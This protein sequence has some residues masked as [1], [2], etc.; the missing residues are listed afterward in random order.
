MFRLLFLLTLYIVAV[1]NFPVGF[2][3][4]YDLK[5]L[6]ARREG[7]SWN[8]LLLQKTLTPSGTSECARERKLPFHFTRTYTRTHTPLY[9]SSVAI[10]KAFASLFHVKTRNFFLVPKWEFLREAEQPGGNYYCCESACNVSILRLPLRFYQMWH[11]FI[12]T[13]LKKFSKKN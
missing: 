9:C 7:K 3:P 11:G 12:C 10:I 1:T 4:E 2:Y 5:L 6:Y 8:A 13:L